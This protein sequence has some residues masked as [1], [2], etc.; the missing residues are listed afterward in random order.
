MFTG[1][2]KT[3]IETF[4]TKYPLF[5]DIFSE[6]FIRQNMMENQDLYRK[7]IANN[8][9]IKTFIYEL[10]KRFDVETV[11]KIVEDTVLKLP[12]N[13][14]VSFVTSYLNSDEATKSNPDVVQYFNKTVNLNE[15]TK[16]CINY[17]TENGIVANRSYKNIPNI[18]TD[19][20][21]RELDT[22][23]LFYIEGRNVVKVDDIYETLTYPERELLIQFIESENFDYI[24]KVFERFNYSLK[25]ILTLL[26]MKGIDTKIINQEV[27]ET[28]TPY[29]TMLL[30]CFILDTE[31]HEEVVKNLHSLINKQRYELIKHLICYS[32]I[33]E[34]ALFKADEL[35]KLSDDDIKD[36]FEIVRVGVLKKED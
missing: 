14:L 7:Y 35:A 23:A 33:E 9:I 31:K 3:V 24:G 28:L 34:L 10:N 5:V 17:I 30:V 27:V 18:L 36:K 6:P 15:K 32:L 2:F 29:F 11:R 8:A 13:L 1:M 4:E 20:R 21:Y 16:E 25:S 22:S 19:D 12:D 26:V